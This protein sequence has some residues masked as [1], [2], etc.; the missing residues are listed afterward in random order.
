M[1]GREKWKE[2]GSILVERIPPDTTRYGQWVGGTRP[3]GMH[4]CF[5]DVMAGYRQLE[6]PVELF[7]VLHNVGNVPIFVL[8]KIENKSVT[9]DHLCQF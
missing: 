9:V 6:L 3:N 8:V 2:G 5:Y 4:S 1:H 7:P